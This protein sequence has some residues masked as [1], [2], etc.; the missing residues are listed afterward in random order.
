MNE[1]PVIVSLRLCIDFWDRHGAK[2]LRKPAKD[3]ITANSFVF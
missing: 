3:L 2:S 1:L